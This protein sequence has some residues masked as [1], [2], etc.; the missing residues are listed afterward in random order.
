M[1]RTEGGERKQ[2]RPP[3]LEKLGTVADLTLDEEGGMGGSGMPG[4]GEE[5]GEDGGEEG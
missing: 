2:Y 5:G 1:M 4:G 3:R